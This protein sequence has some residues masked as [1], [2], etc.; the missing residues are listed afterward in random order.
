MQKE[1]KSLRTLRRSALYV[2]WLRWDFSVLVISCGR[3]AMSPPYT[4]PVGRDK[5]DRLFRIIEALPEKLGKRRILTLAS[6]NLWSK[7]TPKKP[8]C[9]SM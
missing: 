7:F 6:H 2:N 9:I 3:Y 4:T 5:C 8:N 1:E